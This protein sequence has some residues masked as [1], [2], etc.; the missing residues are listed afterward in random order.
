MKVHINIKLCATLIKFIP[1]DA[2]SY[3]IAPGTTVRSLLE[4]LGVPE[5]KVKF[6]FIDGKKGDIMS[7]LCGGEKV[8]VFPLVCGG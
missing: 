7:P 3:S 8:S 1:E 4:Q 6:I 5:D 2:G